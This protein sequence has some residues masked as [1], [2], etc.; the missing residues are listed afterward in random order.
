MFRILGYVLIML[1]LVV[2]IYFTLFDCP[3]KKKSRVMTVFIFQK[4][5]FY[6]NL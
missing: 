5:Y 1:A 3:H 2:I 4:Y 6:V